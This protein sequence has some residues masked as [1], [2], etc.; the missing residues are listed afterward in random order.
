M[1]MVNWFE[2]HPQRLKAWKIIA[3]GNARFTLLALGCHLSGFQPF[4]NVGFVV[5]QSIRARADDTDETSVDDDLF[6]VKRG[7]YILLAALFNLPT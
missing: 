1:V 2:F 5:V 4:E 7:A 3:Q 6:E